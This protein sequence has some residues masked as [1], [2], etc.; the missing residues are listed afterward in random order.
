MEC[1]ETDC[2]APVLMAGVSST[3]EESVWT[4]LKLLIPVVRG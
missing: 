4:E 2:F 3:F 1:S